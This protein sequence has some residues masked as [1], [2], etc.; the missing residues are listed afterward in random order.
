MLALLQLVP[1]HC[2]LLPFLYTYC[3]Y[4]VH[5]VHCVYLLTVILHCQCHKDYELHFCRVG[6]VILIPLYILTCEVR[7]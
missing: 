6:N 7:Q 1:L 5:I 3:T 2:T 4:H